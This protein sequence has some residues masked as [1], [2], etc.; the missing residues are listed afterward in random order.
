MLPDPFDWILGGKT[1]L[2]AVESI[3]G[4]TEFLGMSVDII[5]YQL[6]LNM[7]GLQLSTKSTMAVVL[8]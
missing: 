5:V 4:A 1:Q 3:D 7:C 8:S 2:D 6:N